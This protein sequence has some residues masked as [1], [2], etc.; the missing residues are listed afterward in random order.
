MKGIINLFSKIQ[1]S[2]QTMNSQLISNNSSTCTRLGDMA[3]FRKILQ[4]SKKILIL[5]GAGVSAESGVPTFRGAGGFWGR[6]DATQLATYEAFAD[7]PS[8]VW[9]FYAYRRKLVSQI[10]PNAGHY[11]IAE[12]EKFAQNA[13][14]EVVVITQN[15]DELHQKA[16]SSNVLELHGSLFRTQCIKCKRIESNYDEP[17]CSALENAEIP[18]PGKAETTFARSE[19]PQC[20]SCGKGLLRPAV[21]WF[22]EPLDEFI[23]NDAFRKV[24]NCDLCLIVEP[25]QL[26]IRRL[27]SRHR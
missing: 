21:T 18:E 12:L 11:A 2:K 16:G 15:I 9:Q 24:E 6:Y 1:S 23:L 8:L 5:T 25:R 17:I 3:K 14:K 22:G 19:L 27:C 13:G 10:A 4:N 26:C 7:R 20:K